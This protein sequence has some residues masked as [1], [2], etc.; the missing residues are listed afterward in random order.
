MNELIIKVKYFTEKELACRCGC[1][2]LNYNLDFLFRLLGFRVYF[3]QPLIVT[4]GCRCKKH[5]S[6][7]GGVPNSL[8]ECED[9]E[10][11]AIDVTSKNNEELFKKACACGLF[12]E[13]EWHKTDGKNFI[14]L[15]YDKNQKGNHFVVI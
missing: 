3:G 9:K 8:H 10:A 5:N 4:S 2:R 13:I 6:E 12:N 7:V 15:G 1:K 14:H 11:S